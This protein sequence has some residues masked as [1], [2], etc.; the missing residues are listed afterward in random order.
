M[1]VASTY[2][3]LSC[4]FLN[5]SSLCPGFKGGKPKNVNL[6]VG[7]PLETK[8]DIT[9]VGPGIETTSIPWALHS[10]TSLNPGSETVGVPASDTKAT[11]LQF[12][13][14]FNICSALSCSFFSKN[15]NNFKFI[16]L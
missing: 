15:G 6:S 16:C 4:T 10:L 7:K 5:N 9:P 8:A 3:W 12:F 11:F 1:I 13:S 2:L 14:I